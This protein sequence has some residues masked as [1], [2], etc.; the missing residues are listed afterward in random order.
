MFIVLYFGSCILLKEGVVA[1]TLRGGH[2]QASAQMAAKEATRI[3]HAP[4]AVG[5]GL[6]TLL[7]CSAPTILLKMSRRSEQR[8]LG[9]MSQ[10]DDCSEWV[11]K[12]TRSAH[13]KGS[14]DSEASPPE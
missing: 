12:H 10:D 13:G 11:A 4:I 6:L 7:T 9:K 5:I 2:C 1:M 3:Y 14:E 8:Q